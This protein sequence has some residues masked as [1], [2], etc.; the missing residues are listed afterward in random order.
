MKVVIYV[1]ILSMLLSSALAGAS[2]FL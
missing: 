2:F 1:M